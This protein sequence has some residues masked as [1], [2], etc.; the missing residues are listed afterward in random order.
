MVS[1]RAKKR[2]N[3]KLRGP[4]SV[5]IRRLTKETQLIRGVRVC[6]SHRGR[7]SIYTHTI[8][9]RQ[10]TKYTTVYRQYTQYT[11]VYRQYTKYTIVYRQY[12]KYKANTHTHMLL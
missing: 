9:Y 5:P 3:H 10:Y 11:I 7:S 6:L 2:F 8:V 12:T 1:Q 4:P